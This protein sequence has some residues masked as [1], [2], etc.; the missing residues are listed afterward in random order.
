MK[1]DEIIEAETA[2]LAQV[3]ADKYHANE[4]SAY[5]LGQRLMYITEYK[6]ITL[7]CIK[8]LQGLE[9]SL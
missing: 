6:K 7:R 9:F 2:R 1:L 8:N 3:V 5:D 4:M